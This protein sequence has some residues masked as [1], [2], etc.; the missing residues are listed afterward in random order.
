M[1]NKII[2][3][4]L[5]ALLIIS[6]NSCKKGFLN[7]P[8]YGQSTSAD[9]WRNADDAI[10]ASNALYSFLGDEYLFAHTEQTWDICSDDQWRAGDHPEDQAIEEFT[11][12]PSNVQ[13]NDSWSRKYEVI[14]RANAVLINVPGIDMD[15]TLKNRILGEAYFIR[16]LI[17]WQFYKIYGQVPVITEADVINNDFNKPKASLDSMHQ[18]IE[19]DFVKAADLLLLQND[20]A[21]TGRATKGAAWGYLAKFYVYRENWEKA[22]EYGN[23]VITGPYALAP[24]FGDNFTPATKNNPE[25]LFSIQCTEGWTENVTSIYSAPRP[26]GGWGFNEPIKDLEDEFETD[27]PRLTYTMA[28]I[29]DIIDIGGSSGPTEVYAGLTNTGYFFRKYVSWRPDGG[30]DNN[31]NIPLLRAADVYLLVAEAKIRSS[32]NGD[33]EI[34]AVRDRNDLP[35]VENATMTEL[36][37]ERRVELAGEN[38]R[39]LD[40]MRWNRA[41]IINLPAHYAIDRGPWKPGRT[42]VVPKNY[43]FPLPQRQIDLSNGTLVQNPDFD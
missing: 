5:F 33:A 38:E 37:H 41:G 13:L 11:Y 2:I 21:N 15:Q 34:N 14:S 31:M 23:K 25:M 4:G 3:T 16:G 22:I 32:Q 42:F 18:R 26:W 24:S 10:A 36:M 12:E 27:D 8:P 17:Y 39:H 6:F 30:L 20:A 7:S 28:K 35:D 9:F 1:K 19:E 29:G 40:L 43:L